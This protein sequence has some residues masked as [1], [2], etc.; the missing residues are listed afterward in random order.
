MP[1][2]TLPGSIRP[3]AAGLSGFDVNAPL[4]S[5]EAQNFKNAGYS[6]CI[7]YLPRTAGLL[8]NN[9]TNA[10]A[11]VILDAGLA[12]MAV[13]HVA[14]PGWQ[15]NTNLGTLYGNFAAT[16]AKQV[17][18][19]PPG[20]NIW[21]DLEGVAP[22]TPPQEVIAYCQAW[23]YSVHTAGYIPGIYVGYDTMLSPEQ[24][25]N[26]ISFQHYWQAYN[27]PDVATRGFQLIQETEKTLNGIPFDPDLTKT[28]NMGD[29][30]LWLS[31]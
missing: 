8:Q 30:A 6:F 13:Q 4:T 14:L 27:G 16:Y 11:L 18:R 19:L 20:M 15:P 3:A 29:S 9:L 7:R 28:D 1:D 12:L 25:Y 23:Y 2:P 22:G 17:V 26:D 21:C 5:A 10:E 31:L 24:L